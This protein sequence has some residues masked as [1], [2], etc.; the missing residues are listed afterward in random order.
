MAMSNIHKL[1]C[2]R[3]LVDNILQYLRYEHDFRALARIAR[4]CKTL[5]GPSLDLLWYHQD[6]LVPLLRIMSNIKFSGGWGRSTDE[7]EPFRTDLSDLR[8]IGPYS[9]LDRNRLKKYAYRIRKFSP[10]SGLTQGAVSYRNSINIHAIE[11]LLDCL[12]DNPFP[13]IR[14]ICWP[15]HAVRAT[16]YTLVKHFLGPKLT[17]ITFAT[18]HNADALT[19]SVFEEMQK[20]SPLLQ[21]LYIF[22]FRTPPLAFRAIQTFR[23]LQ[24]I[25]LPPQADFTFWLSLSLLPRLRWIKCWGVRPSPSCSLATGSSA[26]YDIVNKPFPS[27]KTLEFQGDFPQCAWIF[28]FYKLRFVSSLSLQIDTYSFSSSKRIIK[29][30][31]SSIEKIDLFG[32][33]TQQFSH[34]LTRIELNIPTNLS[35]RITPAE[36]GVLSSLTEISQTVIQGFASRFPNMSEFLLDGYWIFDLTDSILEELASSWPQL[37][38]LSLDPTLGKWTKGPF[39]SSAQPTSACLESFARHCPHLEQLAIYIGSIG[40]ESYPHIDSSSSSGALSLPSLKLLEVGSSPNQNPKAF[41]GVLSSLFPN[42]ANLSYW[43]ASS[44]NA[45]WDATYE[46][47]FPS[48][49]EEEE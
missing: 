36:R 32:A 33:I 22:T 39:D 44:G 41:V 5:E 18:S 7:D 24:M 37:K 15:I 27:L 17:S 13:E 12:G 9:D 3:E 26:T 6:N 14:V 35:L 40:S 23:D 38:Y 45:G 2:V 28:M 1:F 10:H 11:S 43:T 46:L 19:N 20:H 48:V 47:L 34:N 49:S 31:G 29:D 8:C 21:E 42:L 16:D 30:R 25:E 4:T